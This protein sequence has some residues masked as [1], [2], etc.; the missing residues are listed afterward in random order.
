MSRLKTRLY[1][2]ALAR[3]AQGAPREVEASFGEVIQYLWK[4]GGRSWLRGVMWRYRFHRCG[5]RL[6]VGKNAQILY[7][8]YISLGRN[9]CFGDYASVNGMSWNGLRLGNNVRIREHVWIQATS[10]LA[11]L[12]EGLVIG[13]NTYI[14]PRCMIGAGG[15][16]RIGNNV[17]IG[18]AVDLLAE[19]HRFE[20]ADTLINEQGVTRKGIVVEDDVWI[21]NG[22]IILDGVRIAKGAVI[23][24]GS[25]VT[26]NVASFAIVAGNPARVIG[27]RRSYGRFPAG[28]SRSIRRIN[29][30]GEQR[31]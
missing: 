17:T 13:D 24:A 29:I 2:L 26:K 31:A 22:A 23:G 21:G 12:G 18:A 14:G 16:I 7:P 25:I 9:V 15:G 1:G 8:R 10:S 28:M 30:P 20:D 6:F 19:N 11:D 4:R 27:Q 5:G 3:E